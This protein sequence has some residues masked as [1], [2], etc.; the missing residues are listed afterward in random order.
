MLD[1]TANH[2]MNNLVFVIVRI[3]YNK[4][5]GI[6]GLGNLLFKVNNT[7]TLPGDCLYDYMTNTRYG[8]GISPAEINL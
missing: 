2:T 8:A 1:W 7:I 4:D 3:E 5:K 6:T